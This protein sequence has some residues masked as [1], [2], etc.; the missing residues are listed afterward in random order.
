VVTPGMV[1]T[2][3]HITGEPL[4]KGYVPEGLPF[5]DLIHTWL[6]PLLAAYTEEEERLSAQLCATEMLKSGATTFLEAGTVKYVDAVVDALVGIGIRGRVGKFI[7]DKP[8]EPLALRRTTAQAFDQLEQ[9]LK[10]HRSVADGR[11]QAWVL[12]LGHATATDE[13]WL[14]AAKM[15]RDWDT[16]MNFHMSHAEGDPRRFLAEFGERPIEHLHSRRAG[17]QLCRH[18]CRPRG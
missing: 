10:D 1:N 6:D 5:E 7:W 8:Q 13:L 17:R 18:T 3:I 14:V 16:G 12:L 15:A 2:H 11:I 9:T 4:T